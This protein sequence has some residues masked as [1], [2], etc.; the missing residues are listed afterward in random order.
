MLWT[1]VGSSEVTLATESITKQ[2]A[3]VTVENLATA[4]LFYALVTSSFAGR[5]SS[6]LLLVPPKATRVLSFFFTEGADYLPS[7]E[8]FRKSLRIEWFNK[9]TDFSELI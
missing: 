9:I 2:S 4:P 7:G 1:N 6:N 8:E 3:T 5:F